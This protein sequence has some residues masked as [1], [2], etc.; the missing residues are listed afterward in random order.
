M[1]DPKLANIYEHLNN[2]F[3]ILLKESE[4]TNIYL[5]TRPFLDYIDYVIEDFTT[6]LESGRAVLD[7]AADFLYK[8]IASIGIIINFMLTKEQKLSTP[9]CLQELREELI[10]NIVIHY[11]N[12]VSSGYR[13]PSL[14]DYRLISN[15]F[16]E[17]FYDCCKNLLEL[18]YYFYGI[19]KEDI[20]VY[21][22]A[23]QKHLTFK[24]KLK[25]N[26]KLANFN[27]FHCIQ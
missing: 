5:I 23:F 27:R 20:V 1:N 12:Y 22:D 13:Y 3:N 24:N 14:S 6:V 21:N 26:I 25:L 17:T 7:H 19:H 9:E 18:Y 10:D 2:N 4:N 15:T 11:Y 16:I 8:D